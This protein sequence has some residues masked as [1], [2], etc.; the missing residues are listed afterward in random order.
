MHVQRSVRRLS[1]TLSVLIVSGLLLA[2]I[3]TVRAATPTSGF[4][5]T[6]STSVQFWVHDAPWADLHYQ[7]NGGG[8]LN[9]RMVANGSNHTFDVTALPAG[10]KV[11]YSFTIGQ[12]NAGAFDTPWQQLTLGSTP[13]PPPPPPGGDGYVVVWEDTFDGSGG[14][15]AANWAYHVGNGCNPGAGGFDGWGNG[16]WEWY[17]PEQATRQNGNL[18]IRADWFSTGTAI[19]GRTWFQRSARITTKGKRSWTFGRFEARIAIPNATATWPAFWMMGDAC[20]DTVTNDANAPITRFDT[21]ASNWSSCGEVDI[22]EHRNSETVTFQNLFWDNRVGVF[23]WAAN[24]TLNQ[25]NTA[26]A[27]DVRQFLL[28]TIEWE[29]TRIRWFIDRTTNPNPVHTVSITAANQEELKKPFHLIL[30]LALA[31]QFPGT[32]PNQADFPL[33][34]NVDYVRVWQKQ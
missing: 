5:I 27:G 26:N 9:V 15:N 8:Q 13:P 21:M 16:E 11:R 1:T 22:M 4:T 12:F 31:G 19:A 34:M 23:P 20:D 29:P 2:A 25:P 17:R 14:L 3:A 28:Y 6:S 30:N 7:V 18:V 32:T 33:F 10:A 24:T